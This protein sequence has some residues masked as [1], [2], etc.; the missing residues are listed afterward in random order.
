MSEGNPFVTPDNP[1]GEWNLPFE[2]GDGRQVS[3]EGLIVDSV[4]IT[5]A[6]SDTPLGPLPVLLFDWTS[7]RSGP[8]DRLMF[9]ATPEVLRDFRS[10]VNQAV[11]SAL[12]ATAKRKGG[13]PWP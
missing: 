7:S 6:V 4:N 1:L 10:L 11:A 9:F 13:K 2:P 3:T 5:A 12:D 8:L